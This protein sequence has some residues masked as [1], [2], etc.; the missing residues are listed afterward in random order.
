VAGTV[1]HMDTTFKETLQAVNPHFITFDS[2]KTL[3]V[4]LGNLCNLA[5]RHCHVAASP[6]GEK[7]MG[8][9]VAEKILAV[10]QRQP[11]ITLDMTGG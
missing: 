9:D 5:C 7:T 10:L 4:N 6:A 8:R 2:L 11:G 3:Q 1:R